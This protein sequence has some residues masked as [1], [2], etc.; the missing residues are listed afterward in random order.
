MICFIQKCFLHYGSKSNM[1]PVRRG[2]G[3]K[4]LGGGAQ[5]TPPPNE[6][7]IQTEPTARLSIVEMKKPD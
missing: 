7:L 3:G 2:Q 1:S 4:S 5:I 6:A